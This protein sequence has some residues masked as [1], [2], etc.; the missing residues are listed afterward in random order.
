[1]M[2]SDLISPVQPQPR[3]LRFSVDDYYKM[4]EMGMIEDYERSEIIDGELQQARSY[5]DRQS[6]VV[7]SLNFFLRQYCPQSILVKVGK[8]VRLSENDQ[9]EPSIA[10]FDT[11]ERRDLQ[12]A[13]PIVVIEVADSY[14]QYVRTVKRQKY[15]DAGIAEV[16][17]LN[18]RHNVLEIHQNLNSGIYQLVKIFKSGERVESTALP[19][20]DF[21]VDSIIS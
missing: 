17:I 21:E 19:Q 18:L 9:I 12:N 14:L 20:L 5:D 1:M 6:A 11:A 15:A 10:L 2:R 3:R 13:R 8:P 4:I 16:W 7:I